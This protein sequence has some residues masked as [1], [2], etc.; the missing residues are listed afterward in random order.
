MTIPGQEAMGRPRRFPWRTLLRVALA[1]ALLGVIFFKADFRALGQALSG[2]SLWYALGAYL[3]YVVSLVFKA[4]RWQRL[5]VT[6][7]H[8]TVLD[9]FSATA[10]AYLLG[11]A[12][13]GM[14]EFT[15]AYVLKKRA[16]VPFGSVFGIMVAERALDTVLLLS[17]T[18][19]VL[20]L[21]PGAE[22]LSGI[23]AVLAAL[24]VAGLGL[25]VLF[26]STRHRSV[27][28]PWRVSWSTLPTGCTASGNSE[29]RA[30][31]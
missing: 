3:L 18:F 7:R 26:V 4:V 19:F 29:P 9:C 6:H 1:A 25:L 2:I 31:A 30:C 16:R 13:P 24:V 15:R 27:R 8:A 12:A 23:A 28:G 14:F 17:I 11:L 10:C 5:G 21:V 20:V 22:W